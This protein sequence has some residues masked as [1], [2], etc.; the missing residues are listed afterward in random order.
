[1]IYTQKF[2][3]KCFN[4]L[5]YCTLLDVSKLLQAM[6]AQNDTQVRYY[7]EDALDDEEMY[8]NGLMNDD[9]DR[10]VKNSKINA[11]KQ[12]LEIYSEFM[13]IFTTSKDKVE[14]FA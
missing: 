3:E 10:I 5:R 12:R 2:K 1:M 6:E 8:E 9:G 11:H 14:V 7:L 4:T 13:E